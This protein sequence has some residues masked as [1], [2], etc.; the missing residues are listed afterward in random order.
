M[1]DP[2]TFPYKDLAAAIK[3]KFAKIGGQDKAFAY[4]VKGFKSAE[5]RKRSDASARA[6]DAAED[7]AVGVKK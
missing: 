3:N 2:V 4:L 1:P 6:R 5:W 7:A